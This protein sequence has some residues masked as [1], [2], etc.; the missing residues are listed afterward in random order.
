VYP[1]YGAFIFWQGSRM[2]EFKIVKREIKEIK[3]YKCP[4]AFKFEYA[5]QSS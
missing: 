1:G 5:G 3:S 2:E 4:F